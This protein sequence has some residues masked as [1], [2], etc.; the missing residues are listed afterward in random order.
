MARLFGEDLPSIACSL[1]GFA[2]YHWALMVLSITAFGLTLNVIARG[3]RVRT[4]GP[5][6][7]CGPSDV[8]MTRLESA[9]PSEM[10]LLSN[11]YIAPA[12]FDLLKARVEPL[13][14]DEP[15]SVA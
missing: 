10:R 1:L 4:C 5:S 12:T 9:W 8:P 14:M 7:C 6:L 11:R 3:L 2:A 13:D 15:H